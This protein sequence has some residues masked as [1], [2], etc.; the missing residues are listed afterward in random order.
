MRNL[1]LSCILITFSIPGYSQYSDTW[2]VKFSD[3]IKTRYTP[4]INNMTGKGWEYS[5]TIIT[6]GMEKVYN[7]VNDASYCQSL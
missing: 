3:A 2:A 4:T 1:L 7:W 6:H 5:N